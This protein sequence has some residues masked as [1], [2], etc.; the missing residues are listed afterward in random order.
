MPSLQAKIQQWLE[1]LDGIS[2][3]ECD[4]MSRVI[5]HLLD[6]NDVAHTVNGGLL[7]DTVRLYDDSVPHHEEVAVTHWWIELETGHYIDFRARMW[8][9]QT[10]SHGVFM[11]EPGRF[12]YRIM[13]Q[14]GRFNPLPGGILSLMCGI[15]LRDWP[16]LSQS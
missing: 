9:G 8:M 10:A 7:T 3:L 1:P 13:D 2:H 6:K 12:E 5:S 4:G 14:V 16:P 15:D 11:P